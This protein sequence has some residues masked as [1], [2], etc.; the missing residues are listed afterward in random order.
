MRRRKFIALLSGA[1]A[2]PFP[3]D[4]VFGGQIF[5]SQQQFLVH[6]PRDVGPGCVPNS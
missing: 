4:A 3:Q 1:A 6:R 5:I 2:W